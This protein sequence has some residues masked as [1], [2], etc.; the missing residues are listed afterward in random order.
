MRSYRHVADDL[1]RQVRV[2]EIRALPGGYV[3]MTLRNLILLSEDVADDGTSGLLAH[4][5][6]HVRQWHDEGRLRFA[7]GYV[8]NFFRTLPRTRSWGASYRAIPHEVEAREDA[9]RWARS[10]S[11][12]RPKD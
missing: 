7:T 4:E 1:K 6:V 5:L 9:T 12:L 10:A 2:V 8:W 11:Q 3:G